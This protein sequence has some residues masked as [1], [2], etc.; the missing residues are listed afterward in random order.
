M[1]TVGGGG[2]WS[3]NRATIRPNM[4]VVVHYIKPTRDAAEEYRREHEKNVL[5]RIA[6]TYFQQEK[7]MDDFK[8]H[9]ATELL[10]EG[11]SLPADVEFKA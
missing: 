10:L 5:N 1:R 9:V 8:K 3:I 11:L 2:T 4:G 6:F 7:Y